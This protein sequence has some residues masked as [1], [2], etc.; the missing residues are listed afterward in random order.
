MFL[1]ALHIVSIGILVVL[2]WS[3]AARSGERKAERRIRRQLGLPLEGS[4]TG[5]GTPPQ[6]GG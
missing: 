2:V 6:Q 3:M 5:S 4:L 1:L